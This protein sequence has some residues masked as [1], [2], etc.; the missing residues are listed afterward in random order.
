MLTRAL[1][2]LLLLA[3]T[4]CGEDLQADASTYFGI[5]DAL[6]AAQEGDNL[7][8]N[9]TSPIIPFPFPLSVQG[10]I[11]VTIA[12]SYVAVDSGDMRSALVASS[13]R[14][15]EVSEAAS[16]RLERLD[17]SGGFHSQGGA[18]A[19]LEGAGDFVAY[20]C[21]FFDNVAEGAG[22]IKGGLFQ[23]V[24]SGNVE[25][26]YCDIHGALVIPTAST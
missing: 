9:I 3:G 23:A 8:I 4:A 11:N 18:V 12:G 21:S 19:K 1:F 16:L 7:L 14:F 20:N 17:V 6:S 13:D 22:V 26:Q 10:G 25:F 5:A 2:T 15:F 24:D